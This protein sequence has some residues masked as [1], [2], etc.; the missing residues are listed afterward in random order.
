MARDL[1]HVAN[2]A[3]IGTVRCEFVATVAEGRPHHSC[4]DVEATA[5]AAAVIGVVTALDRVGHVADLAAPLAAA[6]LDRLF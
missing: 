2:S 3:W 1:C 4:I 5:R 6:G